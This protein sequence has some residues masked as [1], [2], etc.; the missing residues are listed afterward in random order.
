MKLLL[1]TELLLWAA[2]Y[3]ERLSP[4]ARKLL[5]TADNVLLFSAVSLLEIA[6]KSA[7]ARPDFEVEPRILR[8]GLLD[9]G[10]VELALSSQ[11]VVSAGD[12]NAGHDGDTFDRLLLS[13]AACEGITLLT[14]DARL[15]ASRG[16]VRK[17]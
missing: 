16:L 13:Q 8:R 3:P 4:V 1:D 17:V 5:S 11:H 2:G 7:L 12:A 15:P 10:Y 9:N 14:T 6:A